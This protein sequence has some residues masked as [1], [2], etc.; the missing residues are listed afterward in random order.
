MFMNL[1]RENLL[2]DQLSLKLSEI[3]CLV[4]LLYRFN[5][6][7]KFLKFQVTKSMAI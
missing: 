7:N 6:C 5:Q 4:S 1:A 3:F 2:A